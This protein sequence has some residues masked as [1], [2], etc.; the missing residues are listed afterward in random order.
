MIGA[1]LD[2]AAAVLILLRAGARRPVSI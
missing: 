2:I 1:A